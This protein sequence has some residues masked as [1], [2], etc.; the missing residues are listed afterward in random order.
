MQAQS[1]L[2]VVEGGD[3]SLLVAKTALKTLG[4]NQDE[5]DDG[6]LA[7]IARFLAEAF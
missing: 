5:V 7:A 4:S 1:T 6:M 3:H 2:T